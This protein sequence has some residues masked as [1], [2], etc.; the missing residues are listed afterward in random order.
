MSKRTMTQDEI[1]QFLNDVYIGFIATSDKEGVP[2][3]VPVHFALFEG[4]VYIHGSKS[5]KK[6]DNIKSNK[7]PI[8]ISLS[9]CEMNGFK[10]KSE[11]NPCRISTMY[12]SVVIDG[13]AEIVED[14]DEKKSAL[15]AIVKKLTPSYEGK[16]MPLEAIKATTIIR[17]KPSEITSKFY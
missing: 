3:V 12:K 11:E 10:Y 1:E 2:Y 6:L 17:I 15:Q 7:N 9:A 13:K 16:E 5:G 4:N 8:N 14:L